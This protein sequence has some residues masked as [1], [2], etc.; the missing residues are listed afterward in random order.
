MLSNI[1]RAAIRRVG[2][3]ASQSS[4]NRIFQS[5]WYLQR[6][7]NSKNAD[8]ASV[9]PQ[10]PLSVR[11]S[12]ATAAKAT[13]PTRGRPK[14]STSK[15]TT[16][17]AS[18]KKAAKKPVKKKAVKKVAKK[19]KRK[20][21]K[22]VILTEAQKEK[23]EV[24]KLKLTALTPPK[25]LPKTAWTIL[26]QEMIPKGTNASIA[27]LSKEAAAKYKT[28]TAE[29]LEVRIQCLILEHC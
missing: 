10:L 28:L 5:A 12:Y 25:G 29:E 7:N 23:V 19:P 9:L 18:T 27:T 8:N 6:V 22:K 20:P 1:G 21:V 26:L 13:Q 3:G 2:A 11:R 15:T 4:T 14:G 16:R 17:K 24:K